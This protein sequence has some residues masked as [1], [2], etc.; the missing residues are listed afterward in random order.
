[1]R[2]IGLCRCT[3]PSANLLPFRP[4]GSLS[5][6]VGRVFRTALDARSRDQPAGRRVDQPAVDGQQVISV[7]IH[8][9]IQVGGLLVER[10][11]KSCG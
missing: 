3:Y 11:S 9:D 7:G 8:F 10:I 1:M 5:P 6:Q 4:F 2:W